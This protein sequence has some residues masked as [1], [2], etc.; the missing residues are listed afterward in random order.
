M[1]KILY[2]GP[3]RNEMS[4]GYAS[5]SIIDSLSPVS[6]LTIRPIY[7][8]N[9]NDYNIDSS[10]LQLENKNI[11]SDYDIIIQHSTP[12]LLAPLHGGNSKTKNIA[13][14]I[15]NKT[16]NKKQYEI[17]L[18]DFDKILVDDQTVYSILSSSYMIKNIDLFSYNI[19]KLDDSRMNLDIHKDNQ[20]FYFIGSFSNNKN[21]IKTIITSFYLSFSAE[22]TI[23]LL[24][25]IT[26]SSDQVNQELNKIVNT[27]RQELNIVNPNYY[28]KIVV[29]KL[30]E[31]NIFAIHNSCDTYISLYD[32]GIES[33][34]HK[35]IAQKYNNN[36]IDDSNTNM[37][38][39]IGQGY[40]DTYFARELKLTTNTVFLSESMIRSLQTKSN[41]QDPAKTI[42]KIIC[43]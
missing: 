25:F 10:L 36:I 42:D 33:N 20:K 17:A 14:P 13:I 38:Y 19:N 43:Q 29:N 2:I 35:S 26:E 34:F 8:P 12:Y 41:Y 18:S 23:S 32:S 31:S 3:Y 9:Y 21:I 30:S 4:I 28:H 27:V 7:I 5:R 37:I 22:T 6:D 40:G 1:M 16:I 39:D 24:L 11:I 15:L